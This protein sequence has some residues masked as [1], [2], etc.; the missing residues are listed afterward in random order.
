MWKPRKTFQQ[1]GW[2]QKKLPLKQ[3]V[4]V[5]GSLFNQHVEN[6]EVCFPKTAFAS[7]FTMMPTALVAEPKMV[8]M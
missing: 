4:R 8:A 2:N 3:M 5:E 1:T 6:K 7:M